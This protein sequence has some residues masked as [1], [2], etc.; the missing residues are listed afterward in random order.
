MAQKIKISIA[1]ARHGR[2][3]DA[4]R[5]WVMRWNRNHPDMCIRRHPG[6]VDADDLARAMDA[7]DRQHTPAIRVAE[8]LSTAAAKGGR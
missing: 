6:Y 1:A 3:T 7:W 2:T 4:L 5:A 8:A